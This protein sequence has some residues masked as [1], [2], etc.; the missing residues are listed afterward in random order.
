RGTFRDFTRYFVGS[1][2]HFKRVFDIYDINNILLVGFDN[3]YQDG[4]IL[5]YELDSNANR[6]TQLR[7]NKK[8]GALTYGIF[9][10]NEILW[11][12]LSVILGLRYDNVTYHTQNFLLF[13]SSDEKKF[14]KIIPKI[15]ISLRLLDNFSVFSNFG[16]GIEVPAGNETDPIP[17]EDTVFQINPLLNPIFSKTY[18]FGFKSFFIID[19]LI[20]SIEFEGSLFKIDTE[21]ELIPY[22]QG[23]FYLSASRTSRL[24]LEW[25]LRTILPF[26]IKFNASFSYLIGK[27]DDYMVDSAHYDK[28]KSGVYANFKGN[29]LPGVPKYHYYTSVIIP[30]IADFEFSVYGVSKYFCDDANKI[31]VPSYNL[32]N[33]RLLYNKITIGEKLNLSLSFC[34]NNLLDTKYIGSSFL[35][36]IY[37]KG[38]GIFN[39][40]SKIYLQINFSL[41]DY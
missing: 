9:L 33:F 32:F 36:P 35:N 38:E 2:V 7:T 1:T 11:N 22:R 39:E 27:F 18:E 17:G 6:S 3:S 37:E 34:V 41:W 12:N 28:S 20:K 30:L 21:N 13:S 24:G 19:K 29:Y 16:G 10:Q 26:G 5:F 25:M 31:E 23:K 8:E 40:N 14:E 15:G 4:S